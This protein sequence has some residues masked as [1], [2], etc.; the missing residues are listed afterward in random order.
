MK[1]RFSTTPPK[2]SATP[3]PSKRLSSS[4]QKNLQSDTYFCHF[5]NAMYMGG[6][7]A[8]QKNGRGIL[9][10]DNGVSSITS[11]QNDM[12]HGHNVIFMENCV[13]SIQYIKNKVSEC[14]LRVP[15]YLLYANYNKQQQLQGKCIV[16]DYEKRAV[17]YASYRKNVMVE[18]KLEK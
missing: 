7:K 2:R 4:S 14:M 10:H 11:H 12:K 6:I 17:H 5:K 13:M 16:L 15:G 3:S 18:K 8:F 9:I 1:N